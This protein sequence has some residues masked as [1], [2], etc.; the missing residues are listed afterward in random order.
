MFFN[1]SFHFV[2]VIMFMFFSL[3]IP[4][5]AYH[6]AVLVYH[7][8]IRNKSTMNIPILSTTAQ[9]Y[10]ETKERIRRVRKAFKEQEQV[11]N[12][13]AMKSH[14]A[15]CDV[16]NCVKEI[17]FVTQADKIVATQVVPSRRRTQM[18]KKNGE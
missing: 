4:F 13:R 8:Y 15:G 5:I 1:F 11:M 16:I 2:E 10:Q 3:V 6:Y 7:R 14:E 9:E 18:A 12:A 17:C